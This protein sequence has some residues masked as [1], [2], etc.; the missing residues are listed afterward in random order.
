MVLPLRLFASMGCGGEKGVQ[1]W[2]IRPNILQRTYIWLHYEHKCPITCPGA[3]PTM[4][5]GYINR[6][7][8]KLLIF[9][10][11]GLC[12]PVAWPSLLKLP[13]VPPPPPLLRNRKW[14]TDQ[15]IPPI[16]CKTGFARLVTIQQMLILQRTRCLS[17]RCT[18]TQTLL[19]HT[20][21]YA[22][23]LV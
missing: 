19:E 21:N 9:A 17:Q 15:Q 13:P 7:C 4:Y 6:T 11:Q 10:D 3:K 2:P 16:S 22:V 5:L 1:A 12:K 18:I 14:N 8:I 20:F 23:R